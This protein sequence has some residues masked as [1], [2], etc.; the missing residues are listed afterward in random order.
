MYMY[1]EHVIC[2]LFFFFKQKT[3][4][5]MR[6]SDWSSDVCSSDL[7]VDHSLAG[8]ALTW[9]AGGRISPKLGG[10]GEGLTFRGVYT[11]AIRSPAV[12]ELF[13]ARSPVTD[14]ISDPCGDGSY[15]RGNN[16]SVR[17]A[18]CAAALAAVGADAPGDFIPTTAGRS[19]S[20]TVSGNPNLD[21]E[22]AKSWS[23]GL[24][25][26]PPAIPGFRLDADWTDIRLTGG[27][28]NL[29]IDA[30]LA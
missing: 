27:I 11:R 4:Y 18:N 25:Y 5:E 3:A 13:A 17:T 20:G 15:D 9:S 7:Y 1:I 30:T 19:V 28:E 8:G 21:N 6:I 12:S 10:I 16:P 26:Q 22:K 14:G 24:V 23:L 2:V 29:D